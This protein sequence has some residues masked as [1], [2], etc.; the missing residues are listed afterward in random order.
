VARGKSFDT[1]GRSVAETEAIF[2]RELNRVRL[3]GKAETITFITGV[4]ENR[5]RLAELAR[6]AGLVHYV[7]W[8]NNGRIVIEFE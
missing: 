6:Q 1:H 3:A 2:H 5:E 4:G 7:P 8:A